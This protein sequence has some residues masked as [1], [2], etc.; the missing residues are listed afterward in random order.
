MSRIGKLPV[1]IVEGVEVRIDGNKI[2]VKGP[3]G[4]LHLEVKPEIKLEIKDNNI[5]LTRTNDLGQTRAYHGLFRSLLSGMVLGVT[6]GFIR[7][8]E[9]SGVGYKAKLQAKD[10]LILNIGYS[11]PVTYKIPEG[12]EVKVE[13]ETK[14]TISGI[15]KQLVGQVAA[16]I[17]KLK[18]CEPY[19][20]KGI[21]YV[22]EVIRRKVGKAA[23]AAGAA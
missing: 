10:S 23:K 3:K 21:K 22:G 9:M 5:I 14:I 19:K 18:P 16:T 2:S 1:K 13:E 17:R 6:K 11:A 12:I 20:G 15:D 7:E 8:L 4:E